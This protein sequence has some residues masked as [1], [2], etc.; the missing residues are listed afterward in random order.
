MTAEEERAEII[1][2]ARAAYKAREINHSQLLDVYYMI[3]RDEAE[4]ELLC[5][6][7]NA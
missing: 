1:R 3:A 2:N 5:K 4:Q 6:P 7:Q